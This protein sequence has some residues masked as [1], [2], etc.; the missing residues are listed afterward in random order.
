[1]LFRSVSQS[2]YCG[3]TKAAARPE[4]GLFLQEDSVYFQVDES[5]PVEEWQGSTNPSAMLDGASYFIE[6][7]VASS[8]FI[9]VSVN[10][11]YQ[12]PENILPTA[13]HILQGVA[14]P[15]APS[16]EQWEAALQ[17]FDDTLNSEA[18]LLIS[19]VATADL[20]NKVLQ[21]GASRQD[22]NGVIGYPV[23]EVFDI[24]VS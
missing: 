6:D 4:T 16:Q 3:A 14:I 18:T 24:D 5:S 10:S 20:D 8:D 23:S 7:V 19:P 11:E 21:L 2:R 15:E 22:M 1:M 13:I 9:A 12:I 17:V